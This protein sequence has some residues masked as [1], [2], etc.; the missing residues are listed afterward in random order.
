MKEI[1]RAPSQSSLD[2]DRP[3]K[4]EH[5]CLEGPKPWTAAHVPVNT[6]GY[7]ARAGLLVRMLSRL[8]AG[9]LSGLLGTAW[10]ASSTSRWSHPR[11]LSE[12]VFLGFV[13]STLVPFVG[14]LLFESLLGAYAGP[15]FSLC[16]CAGCPSCV[17]PVLRGTRPEGPAQL[18]GCPAPQGAATHAET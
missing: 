8:L 11:P 13:S 15:S 2:E 1:P 6:S 7:T 14:G 18:P 17:F 9:L 4:A 3:M 10:S 5:R 12:E 16:C